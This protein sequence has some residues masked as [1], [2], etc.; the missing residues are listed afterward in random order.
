MTLH[1]YK[2]P[3]YCDVLDLCWYNITIRKYIPYASI[4]RFPIHQAET[5]ESKYNLKYQD[6]TGLIMTMFMKYE[7]V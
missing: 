7:T 2:T 4:N 6:V 5:F 3:L 1:V